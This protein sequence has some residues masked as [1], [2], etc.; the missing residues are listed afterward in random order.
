MPQKTMPG[1]SNNRAPVDSFLQ[2]SPGQAQGSHKQNALI[3]GWPTEH[4]PFASAIGYW[5]PATVS[6]RDHSSLAMPTRVVGRGE[7]HLGA[8]LSRAAP[9]LPTVGRMVQPTHRIAARESGDPRKCRAAADRRLFRRLICMTSCLRVP[10][11]FGMQII[12]CSG[13]YHFPGSRNPA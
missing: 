10:V 9:V 1:C 6:P 11:S 12:G 7:G 8:P 3:S 13:I 5:P 2:N 4:V